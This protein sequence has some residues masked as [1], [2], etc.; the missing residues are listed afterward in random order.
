MYTKHSLQP[1]QTDPLLTRAQDRRF[2]ALVVPFLRLQ[3]SV[4]TTILAVI[5]R[6][7][8]FVC[9]ILDDIAAATGTT[10]MGYHLSYHVADFVPSSL[11]FQPL[12][13][14]HF[15]PF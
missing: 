12:P 4:R 11:T 13:C 9:T 10:R 2:L 7:P 15:T 6:V 14:F 5:L 8:A 3:H 1:T